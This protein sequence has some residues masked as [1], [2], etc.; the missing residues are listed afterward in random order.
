[1]RDVFGPFVPTDMVAHGTEAQVNRNT[2]ERTQVGA[3]CVNETAMK[4]DHR[5][6]RAFWADDTA[7]LAARAF[8]QLSNQV[9]VHRS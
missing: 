1:M 2:I 5:T 6:R 3:G 4:E 8:N 7:R 9:V